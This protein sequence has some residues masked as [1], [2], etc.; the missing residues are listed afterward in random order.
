MQRLEL[1]N[2]DGETLDI[3]EVFG[4]SEPMLALFVINNPIDEDS[5]ED[6]CGVNINVENATKLRDWL[7]QFI[8]KHG[9][10]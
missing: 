1:N 5:E 8:R 2:E 7:D 10:I 6:T 4:F 3:T 9:S